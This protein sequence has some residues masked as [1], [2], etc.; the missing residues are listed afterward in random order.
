[1]R[2]A[3]ARRFASRRAKTAQWAVFRARENPPSPPEA[4]SVK[5]SA[6]GF[7][8][9]QCSEV[10]GGMRTARARRFASRRA[11]TAQWAVFRARENPPSPPE[12]VSVKKSAGG[13]LFAQCSEVAGGMRTARARRFASRR[14]KTAQ[15]AVFRARENPPSPPEAVSVK[16]SA[17]GFLF[18]RCSEVAGGMR[19]AHARALCAA[20]KHILEQYAHRAGE[21]RCETGR[22][23]RWD[24]SLW[25]K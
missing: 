6:G 3:R 9:A 4:V 13:F 12:A 20:A 18:A 14:A 23:P 22:R 24:A 11:K 16:K 8:F 1:M 19:T 17:G 7:L 5:K 15:W 21:L 25:T 2:T 10:A